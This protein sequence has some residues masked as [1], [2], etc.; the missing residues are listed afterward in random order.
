MGDDLTLDP[1]ITAQLTGEWF[2]KGN[3][4]LSDTENLLNFDIKGRLIYPCSRC[5]KPVEKD[6]DY[7]FDDHIDIDGDSVDLTEFIND[8]LFINEPTSILCREDCKGLCPMCG[9]DLNE[10]P[11]G[12]TPEEEIDP[13]L[14]VLKD[15]L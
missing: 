6:L 8:S 7:H 2:V 13:R 4:R 1:E 11:C 5:L 14:E 3:L 9:K 10:G 15:L 12:C